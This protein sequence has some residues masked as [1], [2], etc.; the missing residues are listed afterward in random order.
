MKKTIQKLVNSLLIAIVLFTFSGN[1]IPELVEAADTYSITYNAVKEIMCENVFYPLKLDN[2]WTYKLDAQIGDYI[3]HGKQVF[4]AKTKQV[5]AEINESDIL[6]NQ[7]DNENEIVHQSSVLCDDQAII[8]FPLLEMNMII[9]DMA[10]GLD[11]KHVSGEFMPTEKAIEANDW[12][13]EWETEYEV[14]GTLEANYG[15]KIFKA[16]FSESPVKMSWEIVSTDKSLKVPAGSFDNLVKINREIKVDVNSLNAEIKGKL[17]NISTTLIIDSDLYYAANIG[18][19][20]QTINKASIKV[21]GIKLP[22][23][24]QGS[25][26]LESY[27]LN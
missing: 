13:L 20:K 1:I 5:V 11:Y 8:M 16:V 24:V 25:I 19:I 4:T 10:N 3:G 23:D 15:G 27:T 2:Q 12:S 9:G 17:V 6:L 21:L 18:L 14:S 22:I 7:L 26:E